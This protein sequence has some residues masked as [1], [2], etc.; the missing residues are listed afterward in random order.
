MTASSMTLFESSLR[1]DREYCRKQ[2]H[3]A[4]LK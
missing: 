4:R 1:V 3:Q 2:Y